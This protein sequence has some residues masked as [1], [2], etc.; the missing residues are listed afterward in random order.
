MSGVEYMA[1]RA[2]GSPF[3]SWWGAAPD[4]IAERRSW[5]LHHIAE[6]LPISYHR[7]LAR[8]D[9]DLTAELRL[10]QRRSASPAG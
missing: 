4:D 2:G 10:R 6:D 7:Q 9:R 1:A 8:R 3:P 5:I